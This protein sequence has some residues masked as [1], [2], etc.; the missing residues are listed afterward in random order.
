M[1]LDVTNINRLLMR[2][3][4]FDGKSMLFHI[5]IYQSTSDIISM[6]CLR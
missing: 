2:A 5:V 3:D 4:I 6:G 1:L